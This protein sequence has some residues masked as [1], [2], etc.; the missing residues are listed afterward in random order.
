VRGPWFTHGCSHQLVFYK[1]FK[2]VFDFLTPRKWDCHVVLRSLF[3][4]VTPLTMGLAFTLRLFGA[5]ALHE[6]IDDLVRAKAGDVPF[7]GATDDASFLRR[8]TLD[9]TGNIPA[10]SDVNAFL[11]APSADKRTAHIDKLLSSNAFAVHWADRLT[12]MLLERQDQGT[13]TNEQWRHFLESSLQKKPAWDVMVRHMIEAKGHGSER[14]AMKFLGTAN[15]HTMTENIARLFLGMDLTCARCHDH[16]SVEAWKQSDYWGL[17]AYLNPTRQATHKTENQVYLVEDLATTKI[18]FESVFNPGKKTTGP[19]LPHGKEVEIPTFEEGDQYEKPAEEGLPAVPR[20]HPRELLARD[21][22]AADN[23]LFARNSV[24]R[25]WF[26][27]M[28]QGLFHPLDEMHDHNPP[29]HPQLLDL[30][31][32]EFVAHAFDLKWLLREILLSETYQRDS[33]LPEG[34]S[35]V[36]PTGYQ[37]CSPKPLTPEQLLRAVLRATGNP[38][39]GAARQ[40]EQKANPETKKF[41]RKGYFTGSNT[42]LP[43]SLEEAEAIF[44]LTFGQSPGKAEVD[45]TPGLN[46]ALFLMNDRMVHH[47]LQPRE[48]NLIDRLQN[49]TGTNEVARQLYLSVL[50]RL[51]EEEEQLAVEDY[52]QQIP[53]RRPAAL[54]DLAWALLNS[55]EF[56]FNH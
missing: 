52:L 20:F 17:F 16:P 19:R 28:G 39:Y 49:T 35:Q 10:P 50:S 15:H 12:V 47:W 48:G 7:A 54:A 38:Q 27:L 22:T 41:D 6:Q 51:P 43:P 34:I 42:E 2:K 8:V 9:L 14:P 30:L 40:T 36:D 44:A 45:F 37:V 24:N 3:A 13:V 26:L 55:A 1:S 5:P 53:S 56:R 18:E 33:R 32:H 11:K 46:K 25:M 4:N 23:F 29:S 31:G 21:L